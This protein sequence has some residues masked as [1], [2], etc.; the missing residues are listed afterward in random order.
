MIELVDFND[1]YGQGTATA[2]E[3]AKKTR[4]A[5]GKKKKTETTEGDAPEVTEGE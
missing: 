4:R 5:G 1:V 2:V 3:P